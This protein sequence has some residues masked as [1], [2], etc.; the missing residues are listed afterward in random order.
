MVIDSGVSGWLSSMARGVKKP[1][2][3]KKMHLD[4][5]RVSTPFAIVPI[6]ISSPNRTIWVSTTLA[7]ISILCLLEKMKALLS[8]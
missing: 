1:G 7:A 2:C 8:A 5:E 4:L 6:C 3:G